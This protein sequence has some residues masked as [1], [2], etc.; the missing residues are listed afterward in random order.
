MITPPFITISNRDNESAE[1]VTEVVSTDVDICKRI[2]RMLSIVRLGIYLMAIVANYLLL[3]P[4]VRFYVGKH[5][6]KFS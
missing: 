4:F 1:V 5:C 2:V 6:K 3:S